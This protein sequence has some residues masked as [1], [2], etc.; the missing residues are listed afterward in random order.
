MRSVA[1]QSVVDLPP[2]TVTPSVTSLRLLGNLCLI[3]DNL[4][5]LGKADAVCHLDRYIDQVQVSFANPVTFI[6]YGTA[7]V[8]WVY[9]VLAEDERAFVFRGYCAIGG[10]CAGCPYALKAEVDFFCQTIEPRILEIGY[11]AV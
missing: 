7:A 4:Q 6:D 10:D 3:R 8:H 9:R 1:L 11:C 2:A 5:Q